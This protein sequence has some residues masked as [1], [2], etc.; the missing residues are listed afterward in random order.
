M[1]MYAAFERLPDMVKTVNELKRKIEQ[2]EERLK[3]RG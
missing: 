1:K 3:Q 2:L